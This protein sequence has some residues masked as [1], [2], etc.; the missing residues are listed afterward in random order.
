MKEGRFA[1]D[2][3]AP[4]TRPD[5]TGLSCRWNDIQ[6]GKGTILSLVVTPAKPHDPAFAAFVEALLAELEASADVTQPAPA[7]APGGVRLP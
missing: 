5:L 1:V 4:G 2:A 6:N 3:A 7:G